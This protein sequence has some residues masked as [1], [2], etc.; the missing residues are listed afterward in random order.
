MMLMKSRSGGSRSG[1]KAHETVWLW[2]TA[3]IA[4]LLAVAAV[5]ELLVEGLLRGTPY[6]LAQAVGQDVVTL[7]V[8]LP[9]LVA[10]AVLARLG[11]ERGRL[12]WLGVLVYLVYT[13]AI[14]AFQVRFNALFL[15]YVALLGCS[16]YALIGGLATTDFGGDQ[17]S[18]GGE[19]AGGEGRERL[20]GG[21][22]RVV[23]PG[24]VGRGRSGPNL[25]HRSTE[26]GG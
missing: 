24:L 20:P 16:L 4:A 18:S 22:G 26:R 25:G 13:Y 8:A 21:H 17:G 3:P 7:A 11:S 19:D 6:F 1:G 2:L 12:V 5:S 9:A 15:V 10:G 14:Y 23:L